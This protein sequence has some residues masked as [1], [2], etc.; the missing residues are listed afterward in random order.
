MPQQV[1]VTGLG[2]V[3]SIGNSKAEVI[4][5]LRNLRHG[6]DR[7]VFFNNPR[8]PVKVYGTIK[9]FNTDSPNWVEW[10][11]PERYTLDETY[12]KSLSPHGLHCLCAMLDAIADSGLSDEE[13]A[14]AETGL[15][16]S[17]AGS[18]FMMR[19][20]LESLIASQGM[21]IN[22]MS[23]VASVS[24][25]LNFNLGAYFG[26]RGGNCG[27][28]SACASSSHALG[29][30]YDEISLGRHKR[31]FVVGGEDLTA[32]TYLPFNGMRALSKNPDPDTASRPFDIHRDGFVGTGGGV[33]LL[34]EEKEEALRRGADIYAELVQWGQAS[35]GFNIAMPHPEG[36]GLTLAMR[37]ALRHAGLEPG[38]VDYVN[39]HATST[40]PGDTSELLSL[41]EVFL[42]SGASPKISSTKALTGHGLSMA[43]VM[44][45]AFTVLGLKEGFIIGAAHLKDPDPLCEG[46]EFPLETLD[47]EHRVAISNSS[48]F[49]GSNVCLVFRRFPND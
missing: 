15:F 38:D 24:G 19:H 45:A 39:A 48:G 8:I 46:L 12:L 44:E 20:N 41:R 30:G 1:V 3:T 27:F 16:A 14:S 6:F 21:R 33:A 29:Y 47:Q 37:N 23:V 35:D 25:T 4:E 26:I 36:S 28:V 42:E 43:G 10:K 18:T 22:P 40:P 17:S 49:G 5:S 13:V 31:I 32:E 34:L 9:E 7:L 11:Y 2:L